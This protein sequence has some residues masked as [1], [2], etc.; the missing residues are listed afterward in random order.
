MRKCPKVLTG[1]WNRYLCFNEVD[2]CWL[3]LRWV[4]VCNILASLTLWPRRLNLLWL[5]LRRLCCILSLLECHHLKIWCW[6]RIIILKV[7]TI[8]LLDLQLLLLWKELKFFLKLWP[9]LTHVD[10][11]SF[12]SL[13]LNRILEAKFFWINGRNTSSW[14]VQ[15]HK[16]QLLL[17]VVVATTACNSLCGAWWLSRILVL[18]KDDHISF[19][20]PILLLNHLESF[21]VFLFKL[22]EHVVHLLGELWSLL[23]NYFRALFGANS[24]SR[25]IVHLRIYRGGNLITYT[26]YNMKLRTYLTNLLIIIFFFLLRDAWNETFRLGVLFC[27]FKML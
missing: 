22:I 18:I 14:G 9:M 12:C 1:L 3:D 25:L 21:A 27:F 2:S 17:V 16:S 13:R 8:D 24:A 6:V 5:L 15:L 7:I 11:L 19:S 20:L 26:L 10:H 23:N 4:F